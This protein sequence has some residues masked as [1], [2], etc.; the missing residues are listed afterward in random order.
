MQ[1]VPSLINGELIISSSL[2]NIP[3]TNPANN[4]VIAELTCT[5]ETKIITV[6]WFE[7]DIPSGSNMT[8]SLK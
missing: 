3:V 1:L 7:D 4:N 2:P 6:R 5:T 8:I